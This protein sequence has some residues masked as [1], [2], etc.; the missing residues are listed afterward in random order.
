MP[1]LSGHLQEVKNNG[2][3]LNRQAQKVVAVTYRSWSF[4][5]GSINC[6]ALGKVLV[7]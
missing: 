5:R 4:N 3:S 6:K 1:R 2:K 7:F